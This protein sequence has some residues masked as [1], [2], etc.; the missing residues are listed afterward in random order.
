MDAAQ[1]IKL[2]RIN[3]ELVNRTV[4]L[5]ST[6]EYRDALDA[7]KKTEQDVIPRVTDAQDREEL[8]ELC[9]HVRVAMGSGDQK[10]ME[11]ASAML[12]DRL[13]NYAYLL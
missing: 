11:E 2:K 13:L 10:K 12:N 6:P 7:L 3:E 4:D 8:E 5:E 1:L 9:R